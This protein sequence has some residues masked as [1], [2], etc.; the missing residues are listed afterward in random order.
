MNVLMA[1]LHLYGQFVNRRPT[2]PTR[3]TFRYVTR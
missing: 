1:L 2:P 3:P